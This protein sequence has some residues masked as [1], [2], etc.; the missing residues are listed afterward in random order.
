MPK[1]KG[2]E[3]ELFIITIPLSGFIFSISG[4][5]LWRSTDS[6]EFLEIRGRN[7]FFF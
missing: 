5:V 6:V 7:F 2:K 4:A 1:V 3:K